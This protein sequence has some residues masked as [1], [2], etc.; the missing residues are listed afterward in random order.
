[1][2]VFVVINCDAVADLVRKY[3]DSNDENTARDLSYKLESLS[4]DLKQTLS[5]KGAHLHVVGGSRIVADVPDEVAD[6][7]LPYVRDSR[8]RFGVPV[9]VGVGRS[10]AEAMA[11]ERQSRRSGELEVYGTHQD[12]AKSGD[13]DDRE[14]NAPINTFDPTVPQRGE[15]KPE[16]PKV[17]SRPTVEES[18]QHAV[19]MAQVILGQPPQPAPP[20]ASAAQQQAPGQPAPGQQQPPGQQEQP[21]GGTEKDEASPDDYVPTVDELKQMVVRGKQQKA[22]ATQQAAQPAAQA[23]QQQQP[24]AHDKV[25]QALSMLRSHLP[26]ILA[27]ADKNP[28]AFSQAM[29]L[30]SKLAA[31]SKAM[32]AKMP[33]S[34]TAKLEKAAR[35]LAPKNRSPRFPVGTSFR[36]RKKVMVS[37]REVWRNV[38]SGQVKDDASGAAISSKSYPTYGQKG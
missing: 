16:Q 19:T 30:V 7:I 38:K 3:Q 15:K 21:A 18:A 29:N 34:I 27:L 5:E 6:C 8:D 10:M 24:Q 26:A 17:P 35:R 2:R 28:K 1:M 25:H 36:G 33:E 14:M 12:T 11:A 23:Q 37:G 20:P 32:G 22:A 4:S 31:L 13:I 9:A